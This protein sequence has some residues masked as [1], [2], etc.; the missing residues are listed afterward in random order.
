ML[1]RITY[2]VVQ[3]V[4]CRLHMQGQQKVLQLCSV[5]APDLF[6]PEQPV[7]QCQGV[8]DRLQHMALG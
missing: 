5:Q 6:G 1:K 4:D 3:A 8:G 7:N 2:H